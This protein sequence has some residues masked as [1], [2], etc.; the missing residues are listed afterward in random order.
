MP[1]NKKNIITLD[2]NKDI[3]ILLK[4]EDDSTNIT[5]NITPFH[6]PIAFITLAHIQKK[7]LELQ[8][9]ENMKEDNE[10]T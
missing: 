1:E 3:F 8:Q 10:Q 2:K 5:V 7:L 9:Q 6:R 4:L